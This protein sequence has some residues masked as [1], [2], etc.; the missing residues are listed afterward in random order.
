M[1]NFY[2]NL[3]LSREN[4]AARF[5]KQLIINLNIPKESLNVLKEKKK[6]IKPL[7]QQLGSVSCL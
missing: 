2:N 3:N 6:T 7:H 4:D 5:N 1:N